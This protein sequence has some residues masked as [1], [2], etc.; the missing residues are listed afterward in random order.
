VLNPALDAAQLAREFA[1]ERRLQI[2]NILTA[3]AAEQI[4][5]CLA[6]DVPWNFACRLDGR[7]QLHSPEQLAAMPP[8]ARFQ[9]GQRIFEQARTG[10][11]FGFMSFPMVDNYRTQ[12]VQGL[13]LDRVIEALASPEFIGFARAVSGD[14]SI[15]KVDAQATRYTAGHFLT[16]HDDAQYDGAQRRCAYVLNFSKDWHADWGGLLQFLD[17][18][19]KVVDSF[20]PRF[21]SLLLF[22]VPTPHIVSY[23]APYATAPRLSITGWFTV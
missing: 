19:G 14:T 9:M 1:R 5:R 12:R 11:A 18:G 4:Y 2:P 20:V 22:A 10:F 17:D 23:V 13:F 3:D 21:N 7:D 6:N 8:E 15:N 16:Q